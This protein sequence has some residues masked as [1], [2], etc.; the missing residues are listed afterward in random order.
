MGHTVLTPRYV[1][2]WH[3][4]KQ[5]ADQCQRFRVL[6]TNEE[7]ASSN[8]HQQQRQYEKITPHAE[9]MHSAQAVMTSLSQE[10]D[11][12]NFQPNHFNPSVVGKH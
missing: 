1:K 10:M 6:F 3:T 7:T 12:I 8:Q 2:D 11:S 9:F 4:F 5:L